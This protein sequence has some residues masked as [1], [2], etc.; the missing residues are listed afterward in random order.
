MYIIYDYAKEWH[1][2]SNTNYQIHIMTLSYYS[3]KLTFFKADCVRSKHE[4]HS[5]DS[6]E[7]C[8]VRTICQG[9]YNSTYLTTAFIHFD[10]KFWNMFEHHVL[11]LHEK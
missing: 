8:R 2:Y 10:Y 3:N 9:K 5:Q 4:K 7:N 1:Y 11:V 6:Q